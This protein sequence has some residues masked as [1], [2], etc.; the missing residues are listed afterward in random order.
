M[1][2]QTTRILAWTTRILEIEFRA[3]VERE[4]NAAVRIVVFESSGMLAELHCEIFR[5]FRSHTLSV[6]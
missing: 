2:L 1:M 5:W 3:N 4:S 6:A